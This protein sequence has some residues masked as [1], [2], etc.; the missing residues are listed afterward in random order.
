MLNSCQAG[1]GSGEVVDAGG[2]VVELLNIDPPGNG[3][4]EVGRRDVV[5]CS[6]GVVEY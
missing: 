2:D 3:Q 1:M 5:E 4:R 6:G